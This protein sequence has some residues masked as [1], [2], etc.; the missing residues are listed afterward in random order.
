M[1]K[2]PKGVVVQVVQEKP[3]VF[4]TRLRG[5]EDRDDK[6]CAAFIFSM[7]DGPEFFEPARPVE[8]GHDDCPVYSCTVEAGMPEPDGGDPDE[9]PF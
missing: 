8:C 6:G 3:A 1:S 4:C 2:T 5:H 7:V 9:V